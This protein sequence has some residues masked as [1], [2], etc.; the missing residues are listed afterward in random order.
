MQ[1]WEVKVAADEAK[2][3]L[4]TIFLA[5]SNLVPPTATI[6]RCLGRE[7]P[8]RFKEITFLLTSA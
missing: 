7:N 1:A 3:K 6:Q 4:N 8:K 2:W 5:W